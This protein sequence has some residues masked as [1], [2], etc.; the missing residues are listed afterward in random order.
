MKMPKA[1]DRSSSTDRGYS[2]NT[3]VSYIEDLLGRDGIKSV[4]FPKEEIERAR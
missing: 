2:D 4:I 1:L 3:R